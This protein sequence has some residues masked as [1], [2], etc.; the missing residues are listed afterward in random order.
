MSYSISLLTSILLIGCSIGTS[1]AN[2]KDSEYKVTEQQS[3]QTLLTLEQQLV[4]PNST[5]DNLIADSLYTQSLRFIEKY[6]KSKYKEQ[7]LVMA[8]KCSD[9]LS[10]NTENIQLIDQLLSEF[11]NS[12]NAP[13]YLYNKGKIYEEKLNDISTAKLIYRDL[14]KRYPKSELAKNM[15]LYL[16]F[17]N[18]SQ[19]EQLDFLKQK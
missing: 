18:Q 7:V 9:G 2:P 1:N 16:D 4:Q 19:E 17:L 11:P 12:E 15:L 10:L 8:A 14:I 3:Y 5:L 13:N 6:P